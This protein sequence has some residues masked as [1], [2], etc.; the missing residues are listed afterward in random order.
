[1]GDQRQ[2]SADSDEKKY[3]YREYLERFSSLDEQRASDPDEAD[4]PEPSEVG[5]EMAKGIIQRLFTHRE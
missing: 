2:A 1:M 3:T 5:R 4:E